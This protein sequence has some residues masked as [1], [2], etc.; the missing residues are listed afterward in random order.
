[1]LAQRLTENKLANGRQLNITL[2]GIASKEG[3]DIDYVKV[4]LYDLMHNQNANLVRDAV[5][6]AIIQLREDAQEIKRKVA[7]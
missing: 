5:N 1:M 4:T 7:A 3:V 6:K 2:S